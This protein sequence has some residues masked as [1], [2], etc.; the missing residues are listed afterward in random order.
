VWGTPFSE[1]EVWLELEDEDEEGEVFEIEMSTPRD[2]ETRKILAFQARD[3]EEMEEE[4]VQTLRN[5]IVEDFQSIPRCGD[6]SG[7]NHFLPV[8]EKSGNRGVST[9]GLP[10]KNAS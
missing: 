1:R 2:L 10:C 6:R 9:L 7:C 3:A 4:R 5:K 8:A